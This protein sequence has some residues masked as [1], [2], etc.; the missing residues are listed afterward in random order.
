MFTRSTCGLVAAAFCAAALGGCYVVPI[1]PDGPYPAIAA[2]AYVAPAP[3]YKT[4]GAPP[5]ASFQARL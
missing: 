4:P 3:V 5:P 2:P 1:A